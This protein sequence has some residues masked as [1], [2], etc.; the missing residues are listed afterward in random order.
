MTAV[1]LSHKILF[2]E[3]GHVQTL[4]RLVTWCRVSRNDRV[5]SARAEK[6]RR[7]GVASSRMP[8]IGP[9][10]RV[11]PVGVGDLKYGLKNSH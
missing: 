4:Q 3:D 5:S 1:A 8:V 11:G 7:P 2:H 10:N 6:L 9:G